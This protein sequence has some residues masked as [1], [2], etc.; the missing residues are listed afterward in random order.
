MADKELED[1]ILHLNR[2][3]MTYLKQENFPL[4]LKTL[5]DAEKL[6]KTLGPN[7]N[8][9]L[10][11]ITLNN[12][13]CF[14]K[15]IN[16][17]NV[18]LKFLKKA[19]EKESIEPIDRVNLAGTLLNMCAIYSQLGKHEQALGQGCQALSLLEQENAGSPNLVSTLIIA[20]HN[21][22]VEYEF[23]SNI[24]QAVECYKSAWTFAVKQMG[25]SNNL[26]L[27]IHK[28]YV[29]A[30]EKLEKIELKST[31]RE[32]LRLS[33]KIKTQEK[34]NLTALPAIR[35]P[36]EPNPYVRPKPTNL[37]SQPKRLKKPEKNAL[38]KA[39]DL[40]QIRFLTGDRLQPMFQNK[41]QA[42]N[43]RPVTVTKPELPLGPVRVKKL[44]EKITEQNESFEEAK[45]DFKHIRTASAPVNINVGNLQERIRNLENKYEDFDKKIQPIKQQLP[46]LDSF[47]IDRITALYEL[48]KLAEKGLQDSKWEKE[49]EEFLKRMEELDKENEEFEKEN[50]E[51]EKENEEVRKENEENAEKIE[52]DEE[53]EGFSRG[54]AEDNR[55]KT[56]EIRVPKVKTPEINSQVVANTKKTPLTVTQGYFRG[57]LKRSKL[58]KKSSA[59]II[60]QKH[61]RRHQCRA[62]YL[63]IRE[64]IIFIQSVYRGHA[65]RRSLKNSKNH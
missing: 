33:S 64:A 12:F 63:E 45:E 4:S 54:L 8:L 61:V 38:E 14:Y 16:K 34:R 27:S 43:L 25:E 42:I 62:I 2:E 60:I 57:Y 19:C 11:G 24:K 55:E 28:S 59:A 20:Y 35:K 41:T 13:G 46:D 30:L 51:V 21:T 3:A 5:K 39:S 52:E 7:E 6:L 9:K 18:A 47:K 58:S 40:A 56:P 48:E 1:F 65:V 31:F 17:P 50:E 10:H 44:K 49:K 15:R 22:G 53:K 26:T 29:E 32:Q 23:L 37:A 36:K